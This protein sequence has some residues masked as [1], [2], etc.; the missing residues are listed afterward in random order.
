MHSDPFLDTLTLQAVLDRCAAMCGAT[1]ELRDA[2]G[3]RVVRASPPVESGGAVTGAVPALP[4]LAAVVGPEMAMARASA[5]PSGGTAARVVPVEQAPVAAADVISGGTRVGAVAILGPLAHAKDAVEAI[6]RDLEA[7]LAQEMALRQLTAMLAAKHDELTT[8]YTMGWS[9]K[10][11]AGEL[12]VARHILA[13]LLPHAGARHGDAEVWGLCRPA[14]GVAGD[15]FDFVADDRGRLH[16]MVAEHTAGGLEGALLATVARA[17]LRPRCAAGLPPDEV[18]SGAS[19]VLLGDLQE[20]GRRMHALVARY[21]PRT[22]QLI[23]ASAGAQPVLHQAAD[24]GVRRLRKT[25]PSLGESAA[26]AYDVVATDLAPGDAAVFYTSATVRIR[27]PGGEPFGDQALASYA[28]RLAGLPPSAMAAGLVEAALA[29]GQGG[30]RDDI[31]VVV[32][33]R[34][35]GMAE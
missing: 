11:A 34:D 7:H 2:A 28:A 19:L 16:V 23:F 1:V 3:K 26:N 24:R 30:P 6:A 31:T 27:S 10:A 4:A 8:L 33:R 18:L 20:A 9:A 35:R 15:L 12:D 22:G 5:A 29:H 25:G 14:P 21:D 13:D 17:T 32:L